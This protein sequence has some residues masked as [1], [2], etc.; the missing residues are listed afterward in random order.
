MV[1]VTS[2]LDHVEEAAAVAGPRGRHRC[3]GAASLS[4]CPT[5][6]ASVAPGSQDQR[7]RTWLQAALNKHLS[8]DLSGCV[9]GEKGPVLD[10][11][12]TDAH[13]PF[14]AEV[15]VGVG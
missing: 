7:L 11:A 13:S 3:T 1:T 8:S 4:C 5:G 14:L 6:A 2:A 10:S 15:G 12:P 9:L